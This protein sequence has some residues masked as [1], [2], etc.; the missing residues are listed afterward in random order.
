MFP[1]I[2]AQSPVDVLLAI[3]ILELRPPGLCEVM[4]GQ[5]LALD[6]L[7]PTVAEIG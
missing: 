5:P 6:H 7:G 4:V 2:G 3:V 1:S